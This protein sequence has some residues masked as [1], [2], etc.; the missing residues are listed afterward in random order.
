MSLGPLP[1][2]LNETPDILSDRDAVAELAEA[3]TALA[4]GDVVRG[5]ETVRALRAAKPGPST[6]W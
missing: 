4:T 1:Q 2:S 5:V 6:G 3:E